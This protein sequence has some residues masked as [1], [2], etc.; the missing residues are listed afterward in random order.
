MPIAVGHDQDAYNYIIYGDDGSSV[1]ILKT[2]VKP[3]P[4]WAYLASLAGMDYVAA[5]TSAGST[6]ADGAPAVTVSD[7]ITPVLTDAAP[8]TEQES[9]NAGDVTP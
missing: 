2:N 3:N 8:S 6:A 4:T 1:A 9:V 7:L 5:N